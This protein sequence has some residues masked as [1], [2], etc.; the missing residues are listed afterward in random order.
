MN[1][2]LELELELE[3]CRADAWEVPGRKRGTTLLV[4]SG[5]W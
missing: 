1:C 5:R 3:T 2:K 4:G